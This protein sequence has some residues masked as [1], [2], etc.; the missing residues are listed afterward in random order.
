MKKIISILLILVFTMATIVGCSSGENSKKLDSEVPSKSVSS[1]LTYV[2]W[3][4]EQEDQLRATIQ[5][6]N[7][8]YPNVKIDLQFTPWAQYWTKLESAGASGNMPDIVTMHTNFA[9][10]YVDANMLAE[11]DDLQ[12]YD[13]SFSYDNFPKGVTRLYT[14]NDKHYGVPKDIDCVVL[15]YNKELFD[16]AGL[17]Y[18]NENW[19]WDDLGN[20]AS[21]LTNKKSDLYGIAAF[22]NMQEAWGNFIYQNG[23]SVINEEKN[24]SGLDN[25]KSIEAM[26][27]FMDL[28]DKYSPD[29][30]QLS[31]TDRI[32]IFASGRLGMLTIG[33]WQ[34][35]KLTSNNNI[36]KKFDIVP[37][38]AANDGDKATISNG[39][40]Y[41]I[42][43]NTKNVGVAK[44]FVAYLGSKDAN[45]RAAIGV[46]IPAYNGVINTWSDK[47]K[48]LYNTKAIVDSMKYGVQ[49]V[50][51][52]S[53]PEWEASLNTYLEK[54][55]N[56]EISVK[57][58][59]TGAT[60]KMNEILKN[61]K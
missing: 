56:G 40:S 57:E 51:T 6:F 19:T 10:K 55:F 45:E 43:K 9:Q 31:E 16:K 2:S 28:L 59:F 12:K 7:K 20:A 60:G 36:A 22:N 46:S 54:L 48:D 25:P 15:A 58:A 8:I 23:G 53:K 37:L 52:K 21:K 30:K 38:P 3:N 41:S 39:L 24:I 1:K 13:S 42:S 17:K 35:S 4:A 44:A 50:S 18:P 33:N 49:Y 47:H 5:G 32:Q 29:T 27:F 26:E 11:I 61:E 34:L 14:F